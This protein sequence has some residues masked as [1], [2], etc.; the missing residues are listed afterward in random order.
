MKNNADSQF[1]RH[2]LRIFLIQH[3]SENDV[4]DICFELD[5]DFESLSGTD[6]PSKIRELIIYCENRGS[7]ENLVKVVC[8]ARS[9]SLISN[10]LENEPKTTQNQIESSID[11]AKSF[12]SIAELVDLLFINET[13]GIFELEELWTAR[14][15]EATKI[16][17]NLTQVTRDYTEEIVNL[18]REVDLLRNSKQ[19]PSK[20]ELKRIITKQAKI[21]NT[22]ATKT[23]EESS[24]F[25]EVFSEGII[26][27]LRESTIL[28]IDFRE[29]GKNRVR[30]FLLKL[31]ELIHSSNLALDS[32]R[33]MVV[34]IQSIPRTISEIV[35]AKKSTLEVLKNQMTVRECILELMKSVERLLTQMLRE[36]NE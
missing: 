21:L 6:K 34:S 18:T 19:K 30:F 14:F 2:N 17:T 24:A 13:E 28:L 12:Q 29:P 4:R 7:F 9:E 35:K 31:Q 10:F 36:L 20:N 23:T 25:E 5:I 1:S 11:T 22:Y 8:S 32:D 3:F 16:T 15:E 33:L 27:F 26:A